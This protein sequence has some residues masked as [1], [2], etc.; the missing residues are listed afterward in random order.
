MTFFFCFLI[1]FLVFPIPPEFTL[2]KHIRYA[3]IRKGKHSLPPFSNV[4]RLTKSIINDIFD[5]NSKRNSK[6]LK[7]Y[8]HT[9]I[10]ILACILTHQNFIQTR[11]KCPNANQKKTPYLDIF[12]AVKILFSGFKLTNHNQKFLKE[13]EIRFEKIK[14]SSFLL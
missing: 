8:V 1:F 5:L 14:L 7:R 4:E 13:I 12:H 3:R 11:K 9:S 2:I 6:R 10:L